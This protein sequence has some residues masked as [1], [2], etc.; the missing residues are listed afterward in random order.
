M[1]SPIEVSVRPSRGLLG[2]SAIGHLLLLGLLCFSVTPFYIQLI[3]PLPLLASAL[4]V[5]RRL[6]SGPRGLR[7]DADR[8]ELAVN[9]SGTG[10][11][12]ADDLE[13]L[14]AL[15]C[16]L[17]IRVRLGG[18]RKRL[19]IAPDS[20]SPEAFRRLSVLARLAPLALRE[21]VNKSQTP[22]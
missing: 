7:W 15:P 18:A 14:L 17:I 22:Q 8:R 10:W 4:L 16:L 11:R 12:Q 20:V 2:L 13:S 21:P 1:F 9:W 3:A 19:L 6:V 5:I